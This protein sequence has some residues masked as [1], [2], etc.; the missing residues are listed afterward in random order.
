LPAAGSEQGPPE[1][2]PPGPAHAYRPETDS[3]CRQESGRSL[4]IDGDCFKA[5]DID[6]AGPAHNV[7]RQAGTGRRGLLA[8]A[9]G[10]SV[11]YV[12]RSTPWTLELAKK[13]AWRPILSVALIIGLALWGFRNVLGRQSAFPKL[14]LDWAR[15]A[16]RV[17]R[18]QC[19][20]SLYSVCRLLYSVF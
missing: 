16:P 8:L 1:R 12:V 20:V 13:F 7:K 17:R 2:I 6:R 18:P 19:E 9:A 15:R 14:Q 11:N 10:L 3:D 5:D 4:L